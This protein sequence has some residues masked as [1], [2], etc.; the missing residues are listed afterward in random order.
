[1]QLPRSYILWIPLPCL[2]LMFI[3]N[4]Y[5]N[6]MH[7]K[8]NV[9]GLSFP[10]PP[11]HDNCSTNSSRR[12]TPADLKWQ[13]GFSTQGCCNILLG[14]QPVTAIA[15][16]PVYLFLLGFTNLL[17]EGPAIYGF[18]SLSDSWSSTT[19]GNC[20]HY[21]YAKRCLNYTKLANCTPKIK[22]IYITSKRWFHLRDCKGHN[23]EYINRE[24]SGTRRSVIG[25]ATML[26]AGR[27]RVLFPMRSPS[28]YLATIIG[29]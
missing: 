6:E 3:A 9:K 18:P 23:Q 12:H 13:D 17:Y 19:T 22:T 11:L 15:K 29:H 28:R 16:S 2:L 20:L 10:H 26:Q 4:L 7:F 14:S 24:N 21:K 8:R 25:W 5:N 27:S 1:M